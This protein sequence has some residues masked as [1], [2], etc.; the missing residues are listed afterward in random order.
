MKINLKKIKYNPI[1]L[2]KILSEIERSV[3]KERLLNVLL[4]FGIF[5]NKGK[6]LITHFLLTENLYEILSFYQ[7]L[8]S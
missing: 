7:K 1:H 5:E 6:T 8:L 3:F 2:N 4:F